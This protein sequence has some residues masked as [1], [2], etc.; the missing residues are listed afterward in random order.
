MDGL[1]PEL[2][3]FHE[4]LCLG[5]ILTRC[6]G[7]VLFD[8][9]LLEVQKLSWMLRPDTGVWSKRPSIPLGN[10]TDPWGIAS[11]GFGHRS[12]RGPVSLF[13]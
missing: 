2:D 12:V 9:G 8:F 3:R 5:C 6:G 1:E 7:A 13:G 11:P 10:T 4:P